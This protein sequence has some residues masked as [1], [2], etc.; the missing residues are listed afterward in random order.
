MSKLGWLNLGVHVYRM[1]GVGN[2]CTSGWGK[3]LEWGGVVYMDKGG[4]W[5]IFD[6]D[7]ILNIL[8]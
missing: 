4:C 5:K 2:T 6:V 3:I 1:C 8:I 7:S